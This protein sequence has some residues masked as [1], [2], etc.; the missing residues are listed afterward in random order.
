ME[1]YHYVIHFAFSKGINKNDI[2]EQYSLLEVVEIVV[3]D[4]E[5]K[6]RNDYKQAYFSTFPAMLKTEEGAKGVQEY[7]KSLEKELGWNAKP[8]VDKANRKKF[9]EALGIIK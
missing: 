6:L 9:F 5:D 1:L 2:L 4:Y 3:R 8:K 7:M